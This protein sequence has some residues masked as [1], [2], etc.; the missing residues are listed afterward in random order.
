MAS[1]E[2]A[3]IKPAKS[4]KKLKMYTAN[5]CPNLSISTDGMSVYNL[6]LRNTL[7]RRADAV[8]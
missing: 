2:K 7:F 3:T 5:N 6:H 1:E 8:I 4:W